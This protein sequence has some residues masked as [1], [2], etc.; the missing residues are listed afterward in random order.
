MLSF[1]C[2][3][4]RPLKL[5]VEALVLEEGD[6]VLWVLECSHFPSFHQGPSQ[7]HFVPQAACEYVPVYC[8][9]F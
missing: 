2:A 3:V 8:S 6:L 1:S 9:A 7:L 5:F 4:G